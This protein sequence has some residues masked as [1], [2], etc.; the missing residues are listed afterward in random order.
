[1]REF[2]FAKHVRICGIGNQQSAIGIPKSPI[3]N[4]PSSIAQQSSIKESPNPQFR[5]VVR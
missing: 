3:I 5:T 2:E 1:M 4:R